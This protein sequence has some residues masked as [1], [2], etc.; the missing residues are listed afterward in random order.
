MSTGGQPRK[1][2]FDFLSVSVFR[3]KKK[4]QQKHGNNGSFISSQIS[5]SSAANGEF[6]VTFLNTT[7]RRN[8]MHSKGTNTTKGSRKKKK[9]RMKA[10]SKS[11]RVTDAKSHASSPPPGSPSLPKM[12]KRMSSFRGRFPSTMGTGNTYKNL[13][14]KGFGRPI[15]SKSSC[16]YFVRDPKVLSLL[17]HTQPLTCSM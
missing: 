4:L 14:L 8:S 16:S 6:E 11:N 10:Q 12:S 2:S 13:S 15:A 5:T 1:G 3:S 17:R 9:N 7:E